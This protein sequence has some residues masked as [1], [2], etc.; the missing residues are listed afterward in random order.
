[1]IPNR[2]IWQ[3][4]AHNLQRWGVGDWI[5]SLLESAGS[6][7]LIGAQ[8]IYFSQPLLNHAFETEQIEALVSLLES[9]TQTRTFA[10]YLQEVS[11]NDI[12]ALP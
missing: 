12:S 4:W 10:A 8:V 2:H 7:S 5:A 6:L 3:S 11:Q 9:E 1:M